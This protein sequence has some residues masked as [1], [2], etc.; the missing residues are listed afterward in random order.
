MAYLNIRK[1][2]EWEMRGLSK[3]FDL[4]FRNVGFP[5]KSGLMASFHYAFFLILLQGVYPNPFATALQLQV[6]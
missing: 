4:E 1:F 5:V 3:P 2:R 6:F